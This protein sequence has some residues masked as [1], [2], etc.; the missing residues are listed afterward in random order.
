MSRKCENRRKPG[1]QWLCVLASGLRFPRERNSPQ[2]CAFRGKETRLRLALSAGKKTVAVVDFTD[3]QGNVTELGR[4]L[5]EEFSTAL[6]EE[7]RS[8]DVIDRIHLKVIL[9]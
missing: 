6:V 3:L 8:F 9:Q 7:P 4:Y 2:A 5:A 1:L